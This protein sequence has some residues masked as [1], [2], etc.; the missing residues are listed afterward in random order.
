MRARGFG[1]RPSEPSRDKRIRDLHLRRGH[2]S[3]GGPAHERASRTRRRCSFE[4][5]RCGRPRGSAGASRWL[6][7]RGTRRSAPGHDDARATTLAL[8]APR[9]APQLRDLQADAVR[10][11]AR[12]LSGGPRSGIALLP[13]FRRAATA[14]LSPAA[15]LSRCSGVGVLRGVHEAIVSRR[16]Q[17]ISVS[18][19]RRAI[20]PAVPGARGR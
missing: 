4:R 5:D 18:L 7:A 15:D 10:G 6:A 12:E 14:E 3:L 1:L 19:N 11:E 17:V 16:V 2:Q 8:T 9:S 20:L 13:P